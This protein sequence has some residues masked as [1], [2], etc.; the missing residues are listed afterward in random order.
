MR[1]AVRPKALT[2]KD[3]SVTSDMPCWYGAAS[4]ESLHS[5]E[6]ME[7][8]DRMIS[9]FKARLEKPERADEP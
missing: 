4:A 6:D 8:S 7:L 5:G 9:Q 3:G 1:R 2:Y